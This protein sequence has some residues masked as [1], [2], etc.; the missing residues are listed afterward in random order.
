MTMAQWS[1]GLGAYAYQRLGWRNAVTISNYQSAPAGFIAE[2]CSLGGNI[3]KRLTP[4]GDLGK[5]VSQIPRHGVDGVFLPTSLIFGYDT[6]SFVAAWSRLH[7]EM[8]HWLVGGD[9]IF[10]AGAKDP[11]L[12]GV[13]FSNPT[14]W[15][16]T[17]SWT[18]YTAELGRAF[19][20]LAKNPQDPL[21]P[22]DAVEGT[23][24]ALEQVRGDLSNGEERLRDA[25]AR[26]RFVSPEGPRRL[27]R[28]HQAIVSSY[29][30]RMVREPSG[31]LG[32][33]QIRVVREVDQTFGGHLG[34]T[35]PVGFGPA[36][37]PCVHGQPPPWAK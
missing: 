30:G 6:E 17:A 18:A 11:R 4:S 13:V 19:P 28:Y 5:L 25:L 37:P 2:F 27:D 1:A 32:I 16:P 26:L 35:T 36:Q 20:A 7:P 14:P 12:L 31:K 8:S 24:E 23:L 3:V 34:P 9:G 22:Y 10:T 29:L 33:R 15:A 21:D